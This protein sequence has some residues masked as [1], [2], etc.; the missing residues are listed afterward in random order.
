MALRDKKSETT[1][2]KKT[3]KKTVKKPEPKTPEVEDV[4]EP[5]D[6]APKEGEKAQEEAPEKEKD[7]EETPEEEKEA[8]PKVA[9]K[10]EAKAQ[11]NVRVKMSRDVSTFIGNQWYRFK[12]GE[13]ATVPAN[14]KEILRNAGCLEAL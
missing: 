6:V 14:V 5:K 11:P 13:T 7:S 4:V 2:T 1:G 8:A 12:K 10:K 9:V 3:V